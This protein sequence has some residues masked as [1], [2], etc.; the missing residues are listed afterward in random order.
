MSISNGILLAGG[1][2]SRMSPIGIATNKHLLP[3][4]DK[5]L[6]YH[7]L[8]TLM[9]SGVRRIALV[10][11]PEAIEPMRR[12]FHDGSQW[13][14]DVRFVEQKE[15]RGIA[16]AFELTEHLFG[17]E[18]VS[19]A[20]GDNIFH[21]DG[22]IRRLEFAAA[23]DGGAT[24][25]GCTVGDPRPFAVVELD[26]AGR[27]LSIEEKPTAPKS[28]LAVPGLY[29]YDSQVWDMARHL[30]PSARGELEIT[31]INRAYLDAQTLKVEPMGRGLAWLDGGTP[32]SLFEASEFIRAIQSRTQLL[33]ASPEEVALRKGFI[34]E[35]ELRAWV[36]D[37]PATAYWAKVRDLLN[38]S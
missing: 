1:T 26:P 13:G 21:G 37:K 7:P 10:T 25:F 9:L 36:D 29:F 35:P 24:I 33:I 16:D 30:K 8:T 22:L 17:G 14:L 12:L 27:P 28:N 11:T 23:Q 32:E 19:L 3:V 34:S 18:A 38:G 15:P 5:P 31:D 2:G 6:I 20:L 4:F